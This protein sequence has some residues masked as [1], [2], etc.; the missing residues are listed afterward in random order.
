VFGIGGRPE[1]ILKRL[2]DV[3]SVGIIESVAKR[4]DYLT[5]RRKDAKRIF[6]KKNTKGTKNIFDAINM[7]NGI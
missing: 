6:T 1:G 4:S 7:I 5:R 3:G 2:L